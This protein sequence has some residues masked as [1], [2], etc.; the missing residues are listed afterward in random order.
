MSGEKKKSCKT[1][2]R[3]ATGGR[4]FGG[5]VYGGEGGKKSGELHANLTGRALVGLRQANKY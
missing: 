5:G 2:G 1:W 3:V 4:R